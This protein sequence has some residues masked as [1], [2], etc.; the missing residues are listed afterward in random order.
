V[1]RPKFQKELER[2]C[3]QGLQLFCFEKEKKWPSSTAGLCRETD[4][5]SRL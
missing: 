5:V 4:A 3:E 1:S 2:Y